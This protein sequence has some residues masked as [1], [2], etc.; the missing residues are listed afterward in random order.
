[1]VHKHDNRFHFK[2]LT[3]GKH[4]SLQSDLHQENERENR[5]PWT[6][7]TQRVSFG[8]DDINLGTTLTRKALD[9]EKAF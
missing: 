4:Y 2:R 8:P 3:I 6:K 9:V 7:L 5:K 1:M